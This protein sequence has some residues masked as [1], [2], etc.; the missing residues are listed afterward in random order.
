MITNQAAAP[1]RLCS[2]YTAATLNSA[3]HRGPD[4]CQVI[5]ERNSAPPQPE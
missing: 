5:V 2:A 3:R 1:E 4:R